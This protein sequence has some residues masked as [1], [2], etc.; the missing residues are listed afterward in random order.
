VFPTSHTSAAVSL[1]TCLACIG[2]ALFYRHDA[3]GL[4]QSLDAPGEEQPALTALEETNAHL[5]VT[6][7]RWQWQDMAVSNHR[8][9]LHRLGGHPAW[10]QDAEF[11]RCPGCNKLMHFLLQLDSEL[12]GAEGGV[13]MWGTG[14]LCY[15]FRCEPCR[16]TAFLTQ[17]S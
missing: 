16:T 3:D 1:E 14:G 17:S 12:P 15:G 4:P 5:A 7:P 2:P 9:N 11:P 13:A 6:P 10:I 8:E